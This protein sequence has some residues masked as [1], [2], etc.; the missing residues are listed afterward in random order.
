MESISL[1]KAEL[2]NRILSERSALLQKEWEEKSMS[3]MNHAI[4]SKEYQEA[5]VIHIFV[6]MNERYEV[7]THPLISKML[8]DGK[9]VIIPKTDFQKN[10][11]H[12]TKLESFSDLQPNK[13]GV[14]EPVQVHSVSTEK[15]ELVL[16]PLL[17]IDKKGNRLGYGKGFYD[18]FLKAVSVPTLGLVFENFILDSIPFDSF[19]QKLDGFISEK[20]ITYT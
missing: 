12:H 19:D 20:G 1:K 7:N 6:S 17:A 16:V 10:E 11:L 2:R 15:I 13:W 14:L 5:K 8:E 9:E 18:R 3:I 4:S